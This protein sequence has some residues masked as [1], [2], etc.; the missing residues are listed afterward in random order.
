MEKPHPCGRG[1]FD[2]RIDKRAYFLSVSTACV[3]VWVVVPSGEV[4]VVSFL[5]SAFLSQPAT[6][7][8]TLNTTQRARNRFM[9]KP[10]GIDGREDE[11]ERLARASRLAIKMR[12]QTDIFPSSQKKPAIR[13]RRTVF[14]RIRTFATVCKG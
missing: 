6:N 7:P 13:G 5:T 11:A 4:T 14:Y 10:P 2:D 9:I 12:V 3:S 1:F 8:T